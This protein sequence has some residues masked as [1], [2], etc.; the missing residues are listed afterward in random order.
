MGT[1]DEQTDGQLEEMRLNR[2]DFDRLNTLRRVRVNPMHLDCAPEDRIAKAR[3]YW[4]GADT[5]ASQL[6]EVL[7]EGFFAISRIV[8]SWPA[9]PSASPE[10]K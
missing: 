3:L 7:F 2:V 1:L 4:S 9:I 10:K 6:T 8:Q 5:G